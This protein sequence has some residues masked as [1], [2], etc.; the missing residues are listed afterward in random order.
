MTGPDGATYRFDIDPNHRE[1]LLKGLDDIG[2]TLVHEGEITAFEKK[3]LRVPEMSA[4][5]DVKYHH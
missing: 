3:H 4:P 1:R 2:L 5:L